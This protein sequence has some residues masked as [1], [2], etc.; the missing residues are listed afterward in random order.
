MSAKKLPFIVK[1]VGWCQVGRSR[2]CSGIQSKSAD[3]DIYPF[4][5][6]IVNTCINCRVFINQY[7]TILCK[8]K[9]TCMKTILSDV[10][11][12]FLAWNKQEYWKVE[13]WLL[14][15]SIKWQR[16]GET[17]PT[18]VINDGLYMDFS[19][20]F[21]HPRANWCCFFPFS[22]LKLFFYIG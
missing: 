9:I 12:Y 1:C 16:R 19:A 10:C 13:V 5:V 2:L 4:K 18:V 21:M 14:G 17:W 3:S 8:K 6:L 15:Y 22:K 20:D 7:G 11:V